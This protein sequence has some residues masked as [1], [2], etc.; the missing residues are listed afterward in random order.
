[1]SAVENDIQGMLSAGINYAVSLASKE[2]PDLEKLQE[3]YHAIYLPEAGLE[4]RSEI[5]T[6]CFGTNWRSTLDQK[7]GQVVS[8]PQI[9]VGNEFLMNGT[10]VVEAVAGGQEAAMNIWD[11][12]NS[13]L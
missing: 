10:S 6:A 1:V 8:H 3:K 11:Y 12:L 9:F 2:N 7:T 4:N 5:Y 13:Q